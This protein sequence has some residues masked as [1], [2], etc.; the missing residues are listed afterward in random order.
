MTFA[1]DV[2]LLA[3]SLQ[4]LK[5]MLVEI[6]DEAQRVG[7]QFHLYK[8]TLLHSVC[9]RR[10]KQGVEHVQVNSQQIEILPYTSS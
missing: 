4:Q 1:D 2:L 6:S 3:S 9:R 10:Q 5:L 7:L 8:T